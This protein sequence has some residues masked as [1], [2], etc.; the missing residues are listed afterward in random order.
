MAFISI[1]F[2]SCLPKPA[3]AVLA[4]PVVFAKRRALLRLV[5]LSSVTSSG[6]VAEVDRR[7]PRRGV[8]AQGGGHEAPLPF[9]AVTAPCFQ[10]VGRGWGE[11]VLGRERAPPSLACG[12]ALFSRGRPSGSG[13]RGL[14]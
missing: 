2:V 12:D 10:S 8:G 13:W 1:L 14:V 4:E 6:R 7:A 3:W 11:E 9:V 5:N